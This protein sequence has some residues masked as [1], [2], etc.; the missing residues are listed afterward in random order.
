MTMPTK[1]I[2]ARDLK[3]GDIF[4]N[5]S[6]GGELKVSSVMGSL[7]GRKETHISFEIG[8]GTTYPDNAVITVVDMDAIHAE[9]L[10]I[11]EAIDLI[12]D[13]RQQIADCDYKDAEYIARFKSLGHG[14]P[15][16]RLGADFEAY[17]HKAVMLWANG[18][19]TEAPELAG[20]E[21]REACK[22]CRAQW[23]AFA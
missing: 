22:E 6:F 10:E 7:T 9:A 15:S 5:P 3:A 16:A 14:L 20:Y 21:Y 1:T 2:K 11:N 13:E 4:V 19:V 18:Y 8:G 23:V 17:R 12:I